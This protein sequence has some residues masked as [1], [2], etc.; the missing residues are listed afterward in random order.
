[1][2]RIV[3]IIGTCH[4]YQRSDDSCPLNSIDE[5]KLYLKSV[6]QIYGIK[7]IGE[8]MSCV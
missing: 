6:C 5:F 8:E 1:M 2:Q 3:Y 4:S 7:A